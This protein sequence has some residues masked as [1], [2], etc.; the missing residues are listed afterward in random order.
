MDDAD[1]AHPPKFKLEYTTMPVRALHPPA[2]PEKGK[3]AAAAAE[4]EEESEEDVAAESDGE[5]EVEAAGKGK[6]RE[7]FAWP[8]PR[9]HLPRALRNSTVDKSKKYAPYGL[10][11]LTVGSWARLA[12][13]LGRKKKGKALRQR[14][15]EFRYM[16]GGEEA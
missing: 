6:G 2:A 4:T 12:A 7:K 16:G 15:K 14:F 11:D 8:I 13:R 9:R 10:A 1:E 3:V 5:V